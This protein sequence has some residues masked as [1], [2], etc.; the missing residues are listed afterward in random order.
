MTAV[1]AP[2]GAWRV[3]GPVAVSGPPGAAHREPGTH[4][5]ALLGARLGQGAG[6]YFPQ[7]G[8]RP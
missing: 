2:T 4:A 3:P 1:L 6:G 5:V 7:F 8:Q